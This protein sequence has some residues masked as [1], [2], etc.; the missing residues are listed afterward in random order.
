MAKKDCA[1]FIFQIDGI[2]QNAKTIIIKHEFE[3]PNF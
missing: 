3:N 2:K 1:P